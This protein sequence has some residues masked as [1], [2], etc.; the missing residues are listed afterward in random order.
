MD[1]AG[2]SW[3]TYINY[4]RII[5]TYHCFECFLHLRI[6]E[7]KKATCTASGIRV[8]PSHLIDNLFIDL[9]AGLRP[10]FLEVPAPECCAI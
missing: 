2:S 10:E 9:L 4:I 1:A 6:D 5:V 3:G 8:P 7:E